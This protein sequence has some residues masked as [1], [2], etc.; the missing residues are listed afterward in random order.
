MCVSIHVHVHVCVHP[1]STILY[2]NITLTVLINV[3]FGDFLMSMIVCIIMQGNDH[4]DRNNVLDYDN[5]SFR[6]Y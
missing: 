5:N 4:T 6:N 3:T 2:C 1:Y